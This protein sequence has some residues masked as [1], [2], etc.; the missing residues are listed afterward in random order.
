LLP[1]VDKESLL[2]LLRRLHIAS[3]EKSV[4]A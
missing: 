3:M 1:E 2:E 4:A